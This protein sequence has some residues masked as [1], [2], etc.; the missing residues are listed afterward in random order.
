MH[1]EKAT[2]ATAARARDNSGR[3][4]SRCGRKCLAV[5]CRGWF[6]CPRAAVSSSAA[7]CRNVRAA[8][9]ASNGSELIARPRAASTPVPRRPTGGRRRSSTSADLG[10]RTQPAESSPPQFLRQQRS[11][12]FQRLADSPA[13]NPSTNSRHGAVGR[14]GVFGR[15]SLFSAQR[16]PAKTALLGP[17]S[18]WP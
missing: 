1:A 13:R 14:S 16:R 15:A 5:P 11:C 18:Q 4:G 17:D 2:V 12:L 6:R 8:H 10:Q 3:T 9:L 7:D